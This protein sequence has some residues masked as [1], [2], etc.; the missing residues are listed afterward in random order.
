M[1]L[2]RPV[3]AD[4]TGSRQRAVL[5]QLSADPY[6]RWVARGSNACER[7]SL[8]LTHTHYALTHSLTSRGHILI[9]VSNITYCTIQLCNHLISDSVCDIRDLRQLEIV[10]IFK[11]IKKIIRTY[12]TSSFKD[13]AIRIIYII[14][15][16]IYTPARGVIWN[17]RTHVRRVT[18]NEMLAV[19]AGRRE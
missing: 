19:L 14:Y 1:R 9:T 4:L 8:S 2:R 3:R 11:F 5:S 12:C 10:N 18:A 6:T 7:C 17:M 15:N 13:Q 16:I